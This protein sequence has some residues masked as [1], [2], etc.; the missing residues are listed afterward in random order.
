MGLAC[1]ALK[2]DIMAVTH[3]ASEQLTI[4]TSDQAETIRQDG[5]RADLRVHDFDFEQAGVGDANSTIGLIKLPP[6]MITIHADLCKIVHSAFGSGRVM[7]VGY[8]AYIDIDGT[9]VAADPDALQSEANVASAGSFVPNDEAGLRIR[10]SSLRGITLRAKVTGG[11]IPDEAT[12]GGR[13]VY[14]VV[15]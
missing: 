3:Q 10:L 1:P 11:S 14:T 12:L 5:Y 4:Q 13:I 6:G 7:D 9:R 8:D 15:G 2:G